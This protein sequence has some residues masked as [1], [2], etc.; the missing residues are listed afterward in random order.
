MLGVELVDPDADADAL[1]ARPPAPQLARAV[2]RACLDRGVI[3]ELGGR[4]DAV[5]RL[6]PPLTLGDDQA[7][8][9]VAALTDALDAATAAGAHPGRA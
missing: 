4:H 6:M 8:R 1:G 7:E 2:R 9:V 5:L 3:I